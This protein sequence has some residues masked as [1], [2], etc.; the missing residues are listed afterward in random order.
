MTEYR[1][2]V[3][4]TFTVSQKVELQSRVGASECVKRTGTDSEAALHDNLSSAILTTQVYIIDWTYVISIVHGT[5]A[6]KCVSG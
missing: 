6:D 1:N 5:R 2:S 4:L 3:L